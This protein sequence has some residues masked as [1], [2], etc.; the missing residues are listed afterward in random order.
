MDTS[1]ATTAKKTTEASEERDDLS[2]KQTVNLNNGLTVR[3]H[4]NY[5]DNDRFTCCVCLNLKPKIVKFR[6]C[7][8]EER[9]TIIHD[10][11]SK[12]YIKLKYNHSFVRDT[13]NI[14][15]TFI[16]CPLCRRDINTA[17][18][19][20]CENVDLDLN[21]ISVTC[22]MVKCKELVPLP[23]FTEHFIQHTRQNLQPLNEIFLTDNS[24]NKPW[25]LGSRIEF[26]QL[27]SYFCH[28]LVDNSTT[29]H[30]LSHCE[31]LTQHQ[32]HYLAGLLTAVYS[33]KL[34]NL[35]DCYL[36]AYRLNKRNMPKLAAMTVF[37]YA[38]QQAKS[39][40]KPINKYLLTTAIKYMHHDRNRSYLHL[41]LQEIL[42]LSRRIADTER[43]M[44]QGYCSLMMLFSLP[45]DLFYTDIAVKY[46][47][48]STIYITEFDR[49]FRAN[50]MASLMYQ[51]E[52]GR[53]S[54]SEL[55]Q[56]LITPGRLEG[57]MNALPGALSRCIIL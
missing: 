49:E 53:R 56:Y 48:A 5:T 45:I 11:C 15:Q 16:K 50:V 3:V 2:L 25:T 44:L 22:P 41:R 42:L 7:S 23:V 47:L 12:C 38:Y 6:E 29:Q 52:Q 24:W 9:N 32:Q 27:S 4:E 39:T 57:H 55:Q 33:K 46:A 26:S 8:L 20:S 17:T 36:H 30:L 35:K 54:L 40:D 31:K 13:D 19:V 10:V 28:Y 14:S 43:A 18:I 1:L 37:L 34:S 21:K 51:N